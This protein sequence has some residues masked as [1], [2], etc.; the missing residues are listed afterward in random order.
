M[1]NNNKELEC[2]FKLLDSD[3]Y[4]RAVK[5][6]MEKSGAVIHLKPTKS[7]RKNNLTYIRFHDALYT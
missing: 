1:G 3:V 4:Q 6:L 5:S 2:V 7:L